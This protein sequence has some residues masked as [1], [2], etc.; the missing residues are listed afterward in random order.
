MRLNAMTFLGK[1]R[2]LSPKKRMEWYPLFRIMRIRVLEMDD[3]WDHVRILLPL[4]WYT[5]NHGGNMFG[6][7]QANLADP[8]P[9]LAIARQFPGYRVM[10]KTLHM[11]F[12]RVGNTVLTL[13]F[14][15]DPAQKAELAQELE[16]HG[17][18]DSSFEMSYVRGDGKICTRIQNT[19][20]IRHRHYISSK[21]HKS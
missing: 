17:R 6:G 8:I 21:E 13:C 16:L 11:E 20:A 18:A 19:V 3:Q 14:D 10:T 4:N 1:M 7:A 5:K 9:A 12:L 15:F 2:F